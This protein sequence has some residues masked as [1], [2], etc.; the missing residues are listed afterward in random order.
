[1]KTPSELNQ[2]LRERILALPGVT[3]K[4]NAGIHENAF[5]VN[6]TMFMHI[7][8]QGHCDIRLS[9]ADQERVLLAGKA[10]KHRW[11]PE[12]GYVTF[13]VNDTSDLEPALELIRMSHEHFS[14]IPMEK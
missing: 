3:E 5:F 10:H 8:G 11:A 2:K 4:L 9:N 14:V 7:H 13:R 1:M 12:D 6:R